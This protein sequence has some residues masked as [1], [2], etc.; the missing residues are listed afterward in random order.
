M[1]RKAA[2]ILSVLV[3]LN[4]GALGVYNGITELSQATTPLQKSVTAGV[5]I[6]GILGLAGAIAFMVRR[7]PAVWLSLAWT[8][9]VTYVSSTAAFAYAGADATVGGAIAAG[10]GAALIGLGIVWCAVA[11]TRPASLHER[12]HAEHSLTH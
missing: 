8:A 11:I 10:I 9:V 5:L 2:W 1:G 4:T 6:Y 3:L 7:R 12:V